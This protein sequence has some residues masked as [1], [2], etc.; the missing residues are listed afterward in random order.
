MRMKYTDEWWD[1]WLEDNGTLDTVVSVQQISSS[2]TVTSTFSQE[3]AAQ[4][5][6]SNGQM[7]LQGL[8]ALGR[9]IIESF[10]EEFVLLEEVLK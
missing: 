2:K 6:K 10:A 3:F 7:S 8:K 9:D 4:Y 1:V 5:R